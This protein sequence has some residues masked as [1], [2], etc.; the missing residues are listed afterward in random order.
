MQE[1]LNKQQ[2]LKSKFNFQPIKKDPVKFEM[3]KN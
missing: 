1:Q 3:G 2:E